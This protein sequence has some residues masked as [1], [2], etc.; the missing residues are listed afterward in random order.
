[1]LN[2]RLFGTHSRSGRF[3][4]DIVKNVSGKITGSPVP[5]HKAMTRYGGNGYENKFSGCLGVALLIHHDIVPRLKTEY[6]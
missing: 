1:L 3:G 4:E 2:R 5:E 6:G